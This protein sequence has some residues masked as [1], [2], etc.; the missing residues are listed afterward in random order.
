VGRVARQ[1]RFTFIAFLIVTGLITGSA[2]ADRLFHLG[3]GYG[4]WDALG[5]LGIMLM[6]FFV[7]GVCVLIFRVF[8]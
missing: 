4:P 5:G 3:W 7:Y 2:L 1:T 6:G 8:Q